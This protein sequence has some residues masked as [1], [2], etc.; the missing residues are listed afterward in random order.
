[1]N[2]LANVFDLFPNELTCLR[3]RRFPFFLVAPGAL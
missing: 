2:P 1:M 3:A